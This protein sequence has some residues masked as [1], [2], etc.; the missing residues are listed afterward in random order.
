[1]KTILLGTGGPKPDPDRMGPAALVEAAGL[2]LLFDAGRGACAQLVR[3]GVRPEDLDAVFVTHHHFDHIASL[4]DVML[5][6]WNN[7]R[8]RPLPVFGPPG[9]AAIVAALFDTVYGA[10]IAFRRRE[11]KL[12]GN[13]LADVRELVPVSDIDAGVA[14]DDSACLVRA[15]RVEHGHGLGISQEEWCCLGFRIEAAGK[16]VAI[17]GDTVACDGLHRLAANADLLVQC[18]YFAE[19]EIVDREH[20]IIAAYILASSGA[21]GKIAAQAG[22][23]TLALTHLRRKSEDL[24]RQVENDAR[25]DF[26]GQV[27]VGHDLMEIEV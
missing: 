13:T 14:L 3:A 18:C 24:L 16:V 22:V 8:R 21:V 12:T 25:R 26:D 23:G 11:A 1:M 9:T 19:A 5:S 27:L 17:S 2:R 20:E 6:A 7:G 4:D 10:D 15:E